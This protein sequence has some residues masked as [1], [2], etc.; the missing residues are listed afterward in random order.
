MPLE[1]VKIHTPNHERKGKGSQAQ[2]GVPLFSKGNEC[3]EK[4]HLKQRHF[5]ASNEPWEM[6]ASFDFVWNQE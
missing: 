3:Q 2:E 4:V 6:K 1:G 5:T